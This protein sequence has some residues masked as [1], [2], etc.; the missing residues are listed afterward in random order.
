MDDDEAADQLAK[1]QRY[2]RAQR[3]L[4]IA[5]AIVLAEYDRIMKEGPDGSEEAAAVK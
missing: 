1:I 2:N 5:Y 4:N 3:V